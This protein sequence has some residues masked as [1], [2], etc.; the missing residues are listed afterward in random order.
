MKVVCR[1]TAPTTLKAPW[2][3]GALGD[4]C[5]GEALGQKPCLYF[6][7]PAPAVQ[8]S[9]FPSPAALCKPQVQFPLFPMSQHQSGNH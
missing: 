1:H 2:C 7:D 8:L 9:Q 6:R 5:R 4:L 3:G